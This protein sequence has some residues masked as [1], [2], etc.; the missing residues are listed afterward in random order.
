MHNI[1]VNNSATLQHKRTH[2]HTHKIMQCFN[3]TAE[4]YPAR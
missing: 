1:A 2:A 4:P 3:V